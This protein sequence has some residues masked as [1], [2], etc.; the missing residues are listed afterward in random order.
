MHLGYVIKASETAH[1][2]KKAAP[3]FT[4]V[5]RT[6]MKM[7]EA[8]KPPETEAMRET[9][10]RNA[11]SFCGSKLRYKHCHGKIFSINQ[12]AS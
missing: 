11:P 7:V 10:R 5:G 1:L 2:M 6:A 9:F 12:P 4:D 3:E 8:L